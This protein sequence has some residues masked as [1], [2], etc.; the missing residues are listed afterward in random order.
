MVSG[1][2]IALIAAVLR[3]GLSAGG[4]HD[5]T[6]IVINN[7]N[8]LVS[9]RQQL[10]FFAQQRL[11]NVHIL[12]N[13]SS[14]PPLLA[15]YTALDA[16]GAAAPARVHRLGANYGSRA[17]W[18][19]GVFPKSFFDRE[20]VLTDADIV[21]VDYSGSCEGSSYLARFRRELRRWPH[22]RKV[23]CALM[24]HDLPAHYAPRPRVLSWEGS[25][26]EAARLLPPDLSWIDAS[27]AFHADIDT[28][29]A[30]YR[31]KPARD[32][33]AGE[34]E[35]EQE[36]EEAPNAQHSYG[37]AIRVGGAH[38]ARHVPWYE[39]SQRP[40]AVARAGQDDGKYIVNVHNDT[41]CQW[42]GRSARAQGALRL[43]SR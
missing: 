10:V 27:P 18:R 26:W 41:A 35:Q 16:A 21:P 30:L 15:F 40:S 6:P 34:K 9:L 1:A 32:G 22:V 11:T 14:Y 19:S 36:Q 31:G 37:P 4:W 13:N 28:T 3:A 29:L 8:R 7:F 25:F 38:A 20:F 39:D 12:D 23:G 33:K 24:L 2:V 17:L 5:A 43:P 42:P